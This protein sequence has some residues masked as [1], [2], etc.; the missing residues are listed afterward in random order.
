[1][2]LDRS[3]CV[4]SRYFPLHLD[5]VAYATLLFIMFPFY[6][7]GP[8]GIRTSVYVRWLRWGAR[9]HRPKI[10]GFRRSTFFTFWQFVD[11]FYVR[12]PDFVV[13]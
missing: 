1:M 3:V 10:S 4:L 12:M 8:C 5:A 11:T 9:A 7:A 2:N 6:V 13:N